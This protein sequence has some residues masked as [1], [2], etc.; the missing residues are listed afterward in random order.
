MLRLS[1]DTSPEMAQEVD[2]R[3][4]ALRTGSMT[5]GSSEVMH[6]LLAHAQILRQLLPATAGI[7]KAI[8]AE[9]RRQNQAALRA[10]LLVQQRASRET[11]RAFRIVLY[12]ASLLLVAVLAHLGLRLRAR[13]Q[14]L[15]RRATFEHVLAGISMRFINTGAEDLDRD[16]RQAL[17]DMAACIGADRAYFLVSGE[18]GRMHVWCR[19][20]VTLPPEWPDG[21]PGLAARFGAG[22]DGIAHVFDVNR[23][24]P[25]PDR[26]ACR[27]FGLRAWVCVASTGAHGVITVLGFDRVARAARRPL[28]GVLQLLRMACDTLANAVDRHV[29]EQERI[30]LERRLQQARRMETVGALA[31]GI[32]HNFNN[33]IGAILGYAEMAEVQLAAD[34]R[35]TRNLDEIRRAGERARDLIDQILAFGRRR[36]AR[37]RPVGLRG[38]IA[39]AASLLR[40]SLPARVDLVIRDVPETAIIRGEP[41]QLQQVIL[42]LCRNAAQAMED[43][44]TIEIETEMHDIGLPRRLS[45]G[46]IMPGR[47]VRIAVRDSGRGISKAVMARIFEPFF[48]TRL[49]GNG[50]GLATVREIVREHG[51]AIDVWSAL[52]MGSRFEVWLPSPSARDLAAAEG[53]SALPF[54]HGETVLVLD[55]DPERLLGDEEMLAAL[56]YEP[57]GFADA[58]VALHSCGETAGRYDAVLLAGLS[59]TTAALNLAPA[60]RAATDVPILL[61]IGTTEDVGAGVLMIAGISEVVSRPLVAAELAT[62]LKRALAGDALQS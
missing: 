4:D 5:P 19:E 61:A 3:L 28:P 27:A 49:T 55:D 50:L 14:S 15:Q 56:G 10:A 21:A 45:H 51:G 20:G 26:E 33:I 23:L 30:R 7:L 34:S 47:Y 25:G 22:I 39:E 62:A 24:P 58:A 54:G 13:A 60:L 53:A 43:A 6:G 36:D 17:A 42:N 8:A 12:L 46:E 18:A 2:E 52:D 1:L 11:A 48:T 44:G 31:S 41:A 37:R 29:F 38:L 59:S 57:V 16:I 32:A 9:P 40:A 35:P